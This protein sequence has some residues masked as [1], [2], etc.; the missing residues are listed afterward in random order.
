MGKYRFFLAAMIFVLPIIS[1]L[2]ATLESNG[3]GGGDW[4][5]ASSWDGTNTPASMSDG[6]T[7]IIHLDDTITINSNLTFNGVIQIYGV[8]VFDKGKLN[9]DSNSVIQLATGSDII[10]LG[11]GQNDQIRIGDANNKISVTE[12]N[13]LVAPNQLT[14]GSLTG[15]GC[16]VTGDC[17]ADPLPVKILYFKAYPE[18]GSIRL[19]WCTTFEKDFDYFTLERSKNGTLFKTH[20]KVFSNIKNSS[21][22]IK[23]KYIDE[24]PFGGLSYYRLKATDMNGFS[25]Y[26]DVI[27]VQL[28]E[29]GPEI[30]LYP[31]PVSENYIIVSYS[32]L[33]E[34]FYKILNITGIKM[35]EGI[36][37]PGINRLQFN[38]PLESG[39]YFIQLED[40]KEISRKFIVK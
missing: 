23:Y 13:N 21:Q 3:S 12:I 26:H 35:E 2:A 4:G 33:K 20:A 16:A 38:N 5:N 36:L 30:L 17:E 32:G 15:G 39:Y 8:L 25:E 27:A 29:S 18:N 28:N 40:S 19:E 34:T 1:V 24:L 9:M 37:H 22:N 7:L 31:N 14:D 11:S 6:D 10:A